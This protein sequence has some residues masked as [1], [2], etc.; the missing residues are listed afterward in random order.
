MLCDQFDFTKWG[1]EKATIPNRLIN[2]SETKGSVNAPGPEFG[3]HN[4]EIYCGL[5]GYK[6]EDLKRWKREKII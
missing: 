5:L 3:A 1:V 6:K 2:F 4:E